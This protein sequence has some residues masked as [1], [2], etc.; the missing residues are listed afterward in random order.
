MIK[1]S[2]LNAPKIDQRLSNLV[3]TAA[4]LQKKGALLVFLVFLSGQ[5]PS[6]LLVIY[7]DHPE[8]N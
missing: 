8:E 4:D 6:F 5:C 1:N 7:I 3:M 2:H